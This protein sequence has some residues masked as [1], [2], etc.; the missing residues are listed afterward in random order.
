MS[1]KSK[2][3]FIFAPCFAC[4]VTVVSWLMISPDSFLHSPSS[5]ASQLFSALQLAATFLATVLSGN[6]HGGSSGEAVYW[7]LVFAQWLIVGFGLFAL[8]RRR[9][10]HEAS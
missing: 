4:A 1:L 3:A 8:F 7:A 5:L 9:G 10:H 2:S 6:V